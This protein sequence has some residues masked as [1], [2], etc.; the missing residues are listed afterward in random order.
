MRSTRRGSA[1]PRPQLVYHERARLPIAVVPVL[2]AVA[3]LGYVAGH[4]GSTGGPSEGAHVAK[5]VNVVIEYPRGWRPA[6]GVSPLPALALTRRQLLA[7]GGDASVAGLLVGTLPADQPGPLPASFLERVRRQ[8]QTTIVNLVELQAYRYQQLSVRGF[9]RALSVFVIPNPG[10]PSTVL[11]CYAQ[12]PR[13]RYMSTCE[14]TVSSVAVAGQT[15]TN[16]LTPEP[17][18][19]SAIS[20]AIAQ[21]DRLRVALTRE[22]RPRVSAAV[23]E[24]LARRLAAGYAAARATLSRLEP[25]SAAQR[26]QATLS[27]AIGQAQAGYTAL[28]RAAAAGSAS[29]YAAAQSRIAAAEVAVDRG[30]ENFVLLGYSPALGAST[31]A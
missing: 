7:P 19:A 30:L 4:S 13:S 31:G 15:Q 8:P 9:D 29:G 27:E 11:A 18:Y 23:V 12:S 16:V 10:A 26:A 28:A 21:L 3:I 20:G 14:Q 22:L 24:R 2:V 17:A 25:S 5:A 1:A 6:A